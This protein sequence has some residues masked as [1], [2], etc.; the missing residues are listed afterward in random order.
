MITIQPRSR[1]GGLLT[2]AALGAAL[3]AGL[4]APGAP[5]LSIGAAG[6]LVGLGFAALYP[7]SI[8]RFGVWFIGFILVGYG[9]GGKGFAYLGMAPLFVGEIGLALGVLALLVRPEGLRRSV[10]SPTTLLLLVFCAWSAAQTLPYLA[11]Y[12][13][14]ALRDAA[15]WGYALFSLII[16]AILARPDAIARALD[17][18]WRCF[19]WFPLWAPAYVI[20]PYFAGDAMPTIP[21]T[22]VPVLIFKPGDMAVHL[23][24]AAVFVLLGLRRVDSSATGASHRWDMLWWVVWL[25]S[26]AIAAATSRGGLVGM[27]LAIVTVLALRPRTSWRRPAVVA[28]LF[29]GAFF[30]S[31]IS[32]DIGGE[33]KISA[34]QLVANVLSIADSKQHIS[35]SGTREWRLAWWTKIVDYTVR[36]PYFWT[37]K[38]FGINLA[39]DDN[40]QDGERNVRPNRSPHSVHMTILARAGVPGLWFWVMF[41]TAFGLALVRAYFR[42]QRTGYDWWGRVNLWVLAY[43]MALLMNGSFDVYIEGPQGGIWFWCIIGLGLAAMLAQQ[44]EYARSSYRGSGMS[45]PAAVAF[46][47]GDGV[48]RTK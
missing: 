10:Q 40:F 18:Y 37:G 3:V 20:V 26:T 47:A 8:V 29:G 16:S 25:G 42:A 19:R 9:Y 45:L 34:R 48:L 15:V 38:G 43:W 23:A 33:R 46:P 21:G 7:S 41:Q 14:E 17:G 11:E 28:L 35:L 1:P 6:A 2:I 44:A 32:I 31:N 22:D 39:D 4:M 12:R 24:G 30:V 5:M 36:G 13:I 27:A